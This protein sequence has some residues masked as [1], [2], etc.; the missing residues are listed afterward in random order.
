MASC[1]SV[2]PS[3]DNP[4]QKI[5]QLFLSLTYIYLMQEYKLNEKQKNIFKQRKMDLF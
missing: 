4:T 3:N 5:E 1:E 2:P